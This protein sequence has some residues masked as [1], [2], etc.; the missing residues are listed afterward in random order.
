M[1]Y[2]IQARIKL[3]AV[4]G[5][6]IP[7]KE[8]QNFFC[9]VEVRRTILSFKLMLEGWIGLSFVFENGSESEIWY[10]PDRSLK[11]DT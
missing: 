11:G 3:E 8:A 6:P 10:D 5:T 2:R 1:G 4:K 9:P 7:S